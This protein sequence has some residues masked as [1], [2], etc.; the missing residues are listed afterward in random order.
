M[1]AC[2]MQTRIPEWRRSD[3]GVLTSHRMETIEKKIVID[4]PVADVY[5]QWTRF[6]EFPRFM[7]GV[8]EVAQVGERRL[9]WVAEIGGKEKEWDAEVL[10]QVPDKQIGWRSINGAKNA[11]MVSFFATAPNQTRVGLRLSYDPEGFI[12]NIGNMLGF[13]SAR[14]GSDLSRFKEFMEKRSQVP[15]EVAEVLSSHQPF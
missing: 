8:K 12:E 11:G 10:Y 9:H 7:A 5:N 4:Q 2:L 3:A 13:I 14:V 6:E 1:M 15:E